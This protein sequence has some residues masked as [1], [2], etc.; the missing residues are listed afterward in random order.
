MPLSFRRPPKMLPLHFFS[1]EPVVLCSQ[2]GIDPYLRPVLGLWWFAALE[3]SSPAVSPQSSV[4]GRM[5]CFPYLAD[6]FDIN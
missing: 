6:C 3:S 5:L 4:L 2:R 1:F